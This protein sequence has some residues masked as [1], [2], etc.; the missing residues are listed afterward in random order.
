MTDSYDPSLITQPDESE[1][2]G[3]IPF[4]A[5][6]HPRSP[7][8]AAASTN[9][10]PPAAVPPPQAPA[11]TNPSP[12]ALVE[13][14]TVDVAALPPNETAETPLPVSGVETP[15]PAAAVGEDEG[16]TVF[17]PALPPF[18]VGE[19]A[20][21]AAATGEEKDDTGDVPALS[22]SETGERPRPFAASGEA[23]DDTGDVSAPLPI[24]T[25]ETPPPAA[26]SARTRGGFE[27]PV[28]R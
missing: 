8:Q 26:A 3:V 11:A 28:R 14:N 12:L 13:G 16:E 1:D 5:E 9:P 4:V 6:I 7:P 24:E 15:P 17:V 20:P 27:P 2:A 23:K 10:S 22:P 21:R 19:T 18:F 25:A